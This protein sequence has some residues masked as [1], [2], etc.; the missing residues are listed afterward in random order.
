MFCS[1]ALMQIALNLPSRVAPRREASVIG[2]EAMP[3]R[4]D[5]SSASVT[6]WFNRWLRQANLLRW[7]GQGSLLFYLCAFVMV[8]SLTLGGGGRIGYL[9]DAILQLSAIPLLI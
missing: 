5:S 8:A 7:F 9:S 2:N 6:M 1:F 4:S 3:V